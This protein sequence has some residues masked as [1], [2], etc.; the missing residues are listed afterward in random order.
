M[1][2][3]QLLISIELLDH[4]IVDTDG[5]LAGKVDDVDIEIDEG[6][7]ATITALVS[8]PGVLAVRMHH[9]RYGWWRQRLERLLEPGRL[10]SARIPWSRVRAVDNTVHVNDHA[11][12]L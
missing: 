6:G 1:D 4:Q 11:A 5:R 9:G 3:R 2:A 12:D 10:G 8:G 7:T